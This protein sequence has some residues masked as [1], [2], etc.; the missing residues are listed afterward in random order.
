MKK[1][2]TAL[3]CTALTVLAYAGGEAHSLTV[4]EGFVD[5]LGF[6]DATPAFS[7]KLPVGIEKQT[8][9]RIQVKDV[10]DSGWVESDQSV[11]VPYGGESLASRQRLEWRVRF[12]DEGGK[13]SGWSKSASFELGLLTSDDWKAQWIRPVVEAEPEA[14][15]QLIKALYRSKEN[16]ERNKDVTALLRKRIEGDVL[17]VNVNNHA[18]GGDPAVGKVKELA[19]IY[20]VGGKQATVILNEN[21]KGNIPPSKTTNEPVAYLKRDFPVS[22]KIEQ[23]RLYVAARGVF[24]VRL[25]GAKVGNDHFAN[26]WTSYRHRLDTLTY[27][28]TGSLQSGGN[29]LRV[30]LG[31]G[32]YAGN[33]GFRGQ[34]QFYGVYP[35]LL[36]QLE[37]TY[38]DGRT[39]TLV[40]DGDW[41]GTFDG[42][43][44]SSSIYNG[45]EYDARKEP[46]DW[47]AVAFNPDLGSAELVPK[48]FAPVR[49]T[50]ALAVLEI[51]EPEPGRFVFDLGQNMVGWARLNIPVE[52]DQTTTIRF[53]EMLNKDGTMYTE[54]YRSAKSTDF[55]TAAETGTIDWEPVFTFHGFRYVELSG[56]PAGAKPSAE[57]VTGVV[58]HSDFPRIGTF[59]S[60]HDK[61]NQLQSNITW[62]QRGNFLDI[63]TDCPQR[64][65]R[66]GWTGDA[67][68]FAPT[69]MFNYDC[70]AFWKSWLGSMR[71]D[72]IAD[73]RIPHV[74]PDVLKQ[75]DSPGWMDAA[76]MIPW[77]VYVRT[78]D[79]DVLADNYDMMEKLVGWYRGQ[80]VDGLSPDMKG[81]GDWLQPY[82][83]KV[84]GDTPHALLGAAFHARSVQILA[85]SARVL[86]R[87]G[88]AEKYAAE[89]AF[90]K[91]AFARYYFDD[92]GKLQNAPET[93]TAYLLAIEF[94]LIPSDLQGKAMGHLV[95]LIGE[96]DNHLRTGFLGTPYLAGVLDRKGHVDL[97]FDLL[98]KETYPSWFFSINQGATTMW[99]RWN[100]YS[101]KDG[102]GKVSM[103]SFNHYAYGAIGQWMYERVAGL[104][105]DPANPGYKHF[106]IRPL[107]APQLDWARAELETAYGK[108][109]SGWKKENG[110]VI[111]EA[112]VPPNTTATIE[113]PNGRKSETV[114]AG[115]YTFEL[116]VM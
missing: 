93:Q 98:F 18:L 8:A 66:L 103:N 61:L 84:K 33:I 17:S 92:D 35:E 29:E 16:P 71:Y 112:V 38:K 97:A 13:D 111:L 113:F 3:L 91:S 70:H 65:E 106:Y 15:F 20:E 1:V 44:R 43:I 32:W 109:S 24:E 100:S 78:G 11:F 2:E 23:A 30:L 81:F 89:A 63:P 105:P 5:P 12:K 47:R 39:E 22:G 40:S 26:G 36:L 73:G 67:Q 21:T 115:S 46:S 14:E 9:Y 57:W 59:E 53:A 64:D 58:L 79:L 82:S 87:V 41:Q 101:H 95:R 88:D 83:K 107:I 54:N 52:K 116:E 102:F 10:W 104:A 72:Q 48:P 68:A 96:A 56:L 7:W 31:M 114:D 94:D 74:I 77:E 42:A 90:V 28:V 69:A 86:E 75:G 49:A 4:G 37:I 108:A 19:V 25:N 45:E 34:R 51:T 76:T 99:E 85:D 27:D 55:Y 60:S 80:S 110:K 62:G 50:E 6:H